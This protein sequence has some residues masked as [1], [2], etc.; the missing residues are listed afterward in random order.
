MIKFG[1]STRE[2]NRDEKGKLRGYIYQIFEIPIEV[3]S[4]II[5]NKEVEPE[6]ENPSL[7]ENVTMEPET[8]FPYTDKPDTGN[9][10]TENPKL[11]NNN[12]TNNNF[13]NNY[14]TNLSIN[15]DGEMGD[16]ELEKAKVL[17]EIKMAKEIPLEFCKDE[18]KMENTV[19]ILTE[20]EIYSDE[21]KRE[22]LDLFKICLVE[23]TTQK[24]MQ[25]YGNQKLSYKHLLAKINKNVEVHSEYINFKMNLVDEIID[26]YINGAIN[27]NV[28]NHKKYLKACIVNGLDSHKVKFLSNV[29]KIS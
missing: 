29:A 2:H 13:T 12:K 22:A 28:K 7:D 24:E 25:Y 26:D 21:L 9:P 10:K 23:M 1:Y 11:L 4:E 14:L 20:N 6:T 19:E 16:K 18:K 15:H 17:E 3:T 8:A 27:N 5:E